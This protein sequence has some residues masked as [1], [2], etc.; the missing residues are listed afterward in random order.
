[1]R[2]T[3]TGRL[4][5]PSSNEPQRRTGNVCL[6]LRGEF[7]RPSFAAFQPAQP[8]LLEGGRVLPVLHPILG[9]SGGDVPDQLRELERVAG[10]LLPGDG[11]LDRL[12]ARRP[13]MA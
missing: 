5:N 11:H 3:K 9:L 7:C 13:T 6:L 2:Q 8:P 10:A 1:M 4:P 12:M